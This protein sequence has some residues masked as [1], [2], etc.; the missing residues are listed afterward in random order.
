MIILDEEQKNNL[1]HDV[2][3]LKKIDALIGKTAVVL[4]QLTS[5]AVD[6]HFT[7]LLYDVHCQL[8]QEVERSEWLLDS[9]AQNGE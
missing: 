6:D 3:V 1:R 7:E 2:K 5:R 4:E 8:L 9:E